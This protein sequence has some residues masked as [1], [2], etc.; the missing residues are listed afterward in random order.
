MMCDLALVKRAG[1]C[2]CALRT[3]HISLSISQPDARMFAL[4]QTDTGWVETCPHCSHTLCVRVS[5][6]LRVCV[7]A[8]TGVCVFSVKL[9]FTQDCFYNL[10][11][12]QNLAESNLK[13]L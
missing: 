1:V 11:K 10:V 9:Q 8:C 3:L 13:K 12:V 6:C 7:C 2:V 4:A 5:A